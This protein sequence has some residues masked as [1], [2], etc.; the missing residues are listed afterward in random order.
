M[1]DTSYMTHENDN[2]TEQ[3]EWNGNNYFNGSNT[4]FKDILRFVETY[5]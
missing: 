3:T 2:I 5:L 4:F 1:M